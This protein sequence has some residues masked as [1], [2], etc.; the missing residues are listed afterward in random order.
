MTAFRRRWFEG[1]RPATGARSASAASRRDTAQ[2]P[3]AAAEVHI[4]SQESSKPHE[5]TSSGVSGQRNDGEERGCCIAT[6][7]AEGHGTR[8]IPS[9]ERIEAMV[10]FGG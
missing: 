4:G 6:E 9:V 7:R 10:G 1:R 2:S 3:A 8:T 5:A